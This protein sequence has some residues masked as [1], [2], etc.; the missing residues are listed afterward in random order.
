MNEKSNKRR[1]LI[2]TLM[3]LLAVIALIG[4]TYAA[5]TY[6][7]IGQ[8]KNVIETGDLRL[9]LDE[10]TSAGISLDNAAP[11]S[12]AT[13]LTNT[14]YKFTLENTGSLPM[15]YRIRIVE[16]TQA[17]T[18]DGCSDKKLDFAKLRY[19][20]VKNSTAGSSL[21]L[22]NDSNYVIDEGTLAVNGK[23]TYELRLWIASTA[24]NEV[25][26][27]HFHGK[28]TVEAIQNNQDF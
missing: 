22:N 2:T 11:V 4:A 16:D 14:P 3:I 24:G 15:K 10:S 21:P 27:K 7:G 26:G 18:T 9:K 6:L 19:Q 25:S 5:F 13:G 20:I 8:K 17:I 23:N 1:V 12:D 28:I